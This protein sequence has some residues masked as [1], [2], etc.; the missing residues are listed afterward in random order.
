MH[1]TIMNKYKKVKEIDNNS[2]IKTYLRI[3]PIINKL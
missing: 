3:E 1:S 2:N